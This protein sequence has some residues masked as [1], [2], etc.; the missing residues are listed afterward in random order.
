MIREPVALALV[1]SLTLAGALIPREVDVYRLAAPVVELRQQ[2]QPVTAAPSAR[3]RTLIGTALG[4]SVGCALDPDNST[5]GDCIIVGGIG[6]AL[7]A[8]AGRT[9]G[10]R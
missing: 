4:A 6:A 3:R 1:G 5:W 8:I 2:P 9:W 10:N 7:G